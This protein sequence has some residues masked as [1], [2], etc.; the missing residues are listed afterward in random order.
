MEC[1][2]LLLVW[3]FKGCYEYDTET[4]QCVACGQLMKFEKHYDGKE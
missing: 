2:H 4:M 1:E 3:K